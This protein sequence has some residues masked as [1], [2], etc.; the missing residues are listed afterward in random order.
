LRFPER[1]AHGLHVDMPHPAIVNDAPAA[2]PNN[3][4]VA[5]AV[6]NE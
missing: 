2:A 5:I 1:G 3:T 6:L 4:A